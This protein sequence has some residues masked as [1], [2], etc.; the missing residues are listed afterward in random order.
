MSICWKHSGCKHQNSFPSTLRTGVRRAR[1][2]S[3]ILAPAFCRELLP[4]VG[5]GGHDQTPQGLAF[6]AAKWRNQESNPRNFYWDFSTRV[7]THKLPYSGPDHWVVVKKGGWCHYLTHVRL[8]RA[9][10]RGNRF[11]RGH[12]SPRGRRRGSEEVP[13]K[14]CAD[15][16]GTRALPGPRPC[17]L[18]GLPGH[19]ADP[20]GRAQGRCPPALPPA[21]ACTCRPSRVPAAGQARGAGGADL[22]RPRRLCWALPAARGRC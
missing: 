9:L 14:C 19:G 6:R 7:A 22:S 16:G 10:T 21:P 4:S 13:A 2:R 18:R 17:P 3:R 11:T 5:R 15:T 1:L 12:I 8:S 20:A